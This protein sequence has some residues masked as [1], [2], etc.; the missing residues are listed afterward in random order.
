ME[1][2]HVSVM[3]EE[4]MTGLNLKDGGIYFDGTFGSGASYDG[5]S[6]GCRLCGRDYLPGLSVPGDGKG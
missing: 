5:E 6:G 1:Y 4:C 3:L 2:K